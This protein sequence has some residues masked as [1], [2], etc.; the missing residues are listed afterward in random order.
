M[1]STNEPL[2]N[3]KTL[4]K[5]SITVGEFFELNRKRIKFTSANGLEHSDRVIVDKNL[6]RP[7]LALAGFVGLFTYQRVQVF[8]NTEINY[9]KSLPEAERQ[10]SLHYLLEFEIP[11]IV[12][13]NGN[14]LEPALLDLATEHEV[15]V[16]ISSY[17]TTRATYFMSDFL[18]DQFAPHAA[19]H[20]A[21]V[22]VY[23][24]GVLLIGR[25]GIGKS[26]IALDL[27]ERGHRLV[28]DD[29]VMVTQKG[30]GIIMGA[31]TDMVKHFMEIR[32]LGLIDIRA[33]FGIRAIRFQKRLE[34]VVQL[35]EWSD[36]AEYER[37]GLDTQEVEILNVSVPHVRLPIY[38][39]KNITV[40]TEVIA[41]NYLLKH[42][43]YDAA[44]EFSRM[45][46]DHLEQKAKGMN[47]RR[48]I[49]YFEHDFE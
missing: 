28:A 49:D 8:G 18:D 10:A 24:V 5:Q 35:E 16:F 13:T 47:E 25:S 7:G 20:G 32:G 14:C 41:L 42:Y 44:D 48:A 3:L 33:M 40:I 30:E 17:E 4:Q 31:G 23:G 45:L 38:P 39:G 21:F 2:K 11:C 29:V 43:G 37:T 15:P 1:P 22:D 26:E 36:R 34:I 9:L 19:I 46:K 27:I 6:H 12:V